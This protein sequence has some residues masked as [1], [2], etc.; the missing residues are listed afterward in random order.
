MKTL[1]DNNKLLKPIIKYPGGK[2]RELKYILPLMPQKINRYFE[3]FVGGG[4]TYFG[5]RPLQQYYINDKSEELIAVYR[6]VKNQDIHF[7]KSIKLMNRDLNYLSEVGKNINSL[8]IKELP[9]LEKIELLENDELKIF[10]QKYFEKMLAKKNNYIE[11]ELLKGNKLIS[12]NKKCFFETVLKAS[13]YATVRNIYNFNRKNI[14]AK[15]NA[16]YFFFVRAFCYSSMFR[17]SENGDFNVPYG[18]MSYNKKNFDEKLKYLTSLEIQEL[19]SNTEIFDLDFQEFMN[20]FNLDKDDFLFVD[21]P[22]DTEFSTY[23]GNEF[24]K[25]DQ[26]RLAEF[27]KSTSA[28]WMLVI[29]D[30]DFIR[31]LYPQGRPRIYYNEFE[32]KYS[33]SFMNRNEKRANHLM[34]TNYE[35]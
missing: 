14:A 29:K 5:V 21:P 11:K 6:A 18:G 9:Q 26:V 33:V 1:Y 2:S 10:Y 7:L 19:F 32:K 23:D 25:L 31:S 34:I 12:E 17:F 27:L 16:A 8:S 30:T 3:P 24:G 22:Y 13:Y 4:A 20:K 35:V 28:K 15:D